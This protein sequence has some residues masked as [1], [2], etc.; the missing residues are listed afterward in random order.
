MTAPDDF[1]ASRAMEPARWLT[2]RLRFD[3]RAR[4]A[5]VHAMVLEHFA[6][7]ESLRILDPA[8]G[9]ASDVRFYG[10]E[11]PCSQE[12][13][14]VEPDRERA[15][16]GLSA[17]RRWIVEAGGACRTSPDR[18]EAELG[19]KTLSVRVVPGAVADLDGRIPLD[20]LDLVAGTGLCD[21]ASAADLAHLVSA[22]AVR[23]TPL[24]MPLNYEGLRFEPE[25]PDD[26]EFIRLY[27]SKSRP[28]EAAG[29]AVPGRP[30]DAAALLLSR[31]YAVCQGQTPWIVSKRQCV[32]FRF[33]LG[34]MA[35]ALGDVVGTPD[36]AERLNRWLDAKDRRVRRRALSARI[37][38]LDVFGTI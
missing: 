34:S 27:E 1:G 10:S 23:K 20:G 31:K 15:A 35:Q 13:T 4:S 33:L 2:G 5:D 30:G 29:G 11:L 18:L 3:P 21:E 6:G 7:F 25:H 14:A 19:E 16:R 28:A 26:A 17:L 22:A 12:W 38:H 32:F 37:L 36:A 24:L 9:W 8:S